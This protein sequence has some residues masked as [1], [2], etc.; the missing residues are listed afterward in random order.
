MRVWRPRSRSWSEQARMMGDRMIGY[1]NG[2]SMCIEEVECFFKKS[3]RHP[4]IIMRAAKR[5]GRAVRAGKVHQSYVA[6][7][8]WDRYK[9][10]YDTE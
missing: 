4:R 5:F 2:G 7:E 8:S 10:E 6:L 3:Y 9:E 1:V